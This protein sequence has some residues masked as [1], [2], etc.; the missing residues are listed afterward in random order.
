M[1]KTFKKGRWEFK[2]TVM[3]LKD[4]YLCIMFSSTFYLNL[5]AI[6]HNLNISH[7]HVL[8]YLVCESIG[9]A[10]TPGLLC[11]P[12]VIV[13]M[14]AEKQMECRMAR[15]TEVLGENLPQRH[16]CPSSHVC[17]FHIQIHGLGTLC[18]N[19]E[20]ASEIPYLL[21]I[22]WNSM[23]VELPLR[24]AYRRQEE[25]RKKMKIYDSNPRSMCS[26]GR[27]QYAR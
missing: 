5:E 17:N 13:K 8:F 7:R 21:G 19:P 10:A 2:W 24:K 25:F 12:R 18:S 1:S 6:W 27:S 4:L 9:T 14:I 22:S 26:S 23:D 11:Q 15:E 20:L 3:S 16:F